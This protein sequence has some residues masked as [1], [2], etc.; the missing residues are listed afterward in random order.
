MIDR[1]QIAHDLA[2]A[3]IN[4]RHGAEVTGEFS[5]YTSDNDVTGSGTVETE[6]L[7]DVNKIH[8]VKVGTGERY[9]FGLFEKSESVESGYEVDPAFENMIG[10]YYDAYSRFLVLLQHR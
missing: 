10:D 3:Y 9:L 6:R 4:N 5:V 7:P 2:M 8:M 1:D